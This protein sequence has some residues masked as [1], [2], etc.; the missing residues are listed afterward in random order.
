[1]NKILKGIVKAN[2]VAGALL[3]VRADSDGK[4]LHRRHQVSSGVAVNL[5]AREDYI[6][7]ADGGKLV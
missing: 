1:M 6:G 3:A 5:T 2:L 7:T 4:R